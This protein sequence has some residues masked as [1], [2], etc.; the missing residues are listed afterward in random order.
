[1]DGYRLLE[2]IILALFAGFLILR[3]RSVLGRRTGH[4]RPR[5]DLRSK[6]LRRQ[7]PESS[8]Q[9]SSEKPERHEGYGPVTDLDVED[10]PASLATEEQQDPAFQQKS[11]DQPASSTVAGGL[12]AIKRADHGFNEHAFIEGAR[13]AFE[14]IVNAYAAGNKEGLRSLL[15]RAVL[16]RFN[17]EIDRRRSVGETLSTTFVGIDSA[18]IVG[19]T[20][21]RSLA[22]IE[23]KIT[24]QQINVTRDKDGKVVD[25]S[26]TEIERLVD[27]WTFERDVRAK[28]P[29][30]LLTNTRNSA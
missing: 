19:A 4:E 13:T 10:V 21:D 5:E 8:T 18:K 11:S 15:G 25:G 14:M 24:S 2:I 3:L 12:L 30:W 22:R 1:M 29:N 16:G 7:P 27:I 17:T 20:L 23:V 9:S 26:P 28:D 6:D